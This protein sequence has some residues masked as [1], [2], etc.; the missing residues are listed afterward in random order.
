MEK[1]ILIEDEHFIAVRKQAGELVVADRFGIEKNI[2]LH[3]LGAYLREKGHKPDESGRDL[4]PV[5]R[6]DR[7]TSGVVLFAKNQET[8]R[9]LS[10][11]FEGREVQKKYWVFTSGIPDWDEA[12]CEVPLLRAEGKKGR[13]RA[14]VDLR[15]GKPASTAFHVVEK[16]GD[17]AFLEAF[18]HTGRL[19]QIRVH[20]W[21][22]G[23]PVLADKAY[24]N[25]MWKSAAFPDLKMERVC[26]HA[27]EISFIH[28]VT[29]K[30]I[31]IECPIDDDMRTLL[32]AMKEKKANQKF[33]VRNEN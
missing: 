11:M 27:R 4:Y 9:A 31:L 24:G 16:F 25:P 18:P 28:P 12:T 32:N 3:Q 2:I 20:L 13:G 26:L 14:L 10:I 7:D 29:K 33:E 21:I 22:L 6:L 15:R 1:R 19:H 8:H 23:I 30:E 17:I 5:H